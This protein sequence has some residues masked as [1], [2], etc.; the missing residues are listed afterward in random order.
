MAALLNQSSLELINRNYKA[1]QRIR[2]SVIGIIEEDYEQE[3]SLSPVY[4]QLSTNALTSRTD[5]DIA[6]DHAPEAIRLA[7]LSAHRDYLEEATLCLSKC[8][9]RSKDFENFDRTIGRYEEIKM[10][11]TTLCAKTASEE[12]KIIYEK[13]ELNSQHRQLRQNV[14]AK[15][16]LLLRLAYGT[17]S[18]IFFQL[19]K[20]KRNVK[21]RL[22]M[23]INLVCSNRE[24]IGRP[25]T[26]AADMPYDTDVLTDKDL[27]RLILRKIEL[28]QLYKNPDLSLA[29]LAKQVRRNKVAVS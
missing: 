15:N 3:V 7:E 22:Q 27:F 11:T 4:I 17:G 20:L 12:M 5:A 1:S 28:K 21:M 9:A 18:I 2:H 8:Y 23:K 29:D 19:R 6:K 25:D 14:H 26:R 13:D 24:G 10:E 16:Q